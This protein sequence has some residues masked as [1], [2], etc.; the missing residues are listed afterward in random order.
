MD[1]KEILAPFADRGRAGLL[2]ALHAVQ[3]Q[4]G[5]I[6]PEAAAAIARTL[7]VPPA[8]VYSLVTFYHM[9]YDR[10][11][12]RRIVRVCTGPVCQAHGGWQLLED[13][14]RL[15]NLEEGQPDE[16]GEWMVEAAP[17]LGLCSH[18]PAVMVGEDLYGP[19]PDASA[20][21]QPDALPQPV[22]HVAG[23]VRRLTQGLPRQ[24][25]LSLEEYRAQGGY[26][27]LEQALRRLSPEA[28]RNQVKA[29]GLWGRGGAAFPT[30]LKWDYAAQAPGQPK[31]V[32]ANA[33]ESEPGT[34]KDRVLL[35]GNPH[36]MLEGLILAGYAIGAREG[37]IYLRGEYTHLYPILQHALE[38]A[39][40]AGYLGQG[41]LG[42]DFTFKVHLYRGA[43]AYVCGE[44]TAL[45]E[46]IEGKRGYPRLKPPYP[47]THG[48]FGKPTVINNVETLANVPFILREGPEAFRGYGTED[49]PGTKLFSLSGDVARP[50]VY[51]APFGL[52]LRDLLE[53]AGGV[54]GTLQA[55]LVGGAAGV[56]L[57]PDDLDWPL[58][59]DE[60]RRRGAPVA[61]GT[62]MVFNQD[63]DLKA[64]LLSIARFFMEE[65][66]GKCFPCQLGTRQQYDLLQRMFQGRAEARDQD[67][68]ANV[69]FAMHEGSICG[70]GQ[71]AGLA[72]QSAMQLWPH[73][74]R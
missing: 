59:L 65:S 24:R 15:Q 49:S 25:P 28:V 51:E 64:L 71:T 72:V 66:C 53:M 4:A 41:I 50:G 7:H 1:W 57:P 73:L 31:Y 60:G 29:A 6:P 52:T 27:A 18:A 36:L 14:L 32:V 58:T 69:I 23:P 70:L 68:L 45:F 37:Y 16:A 19:A 21:F 44:E 43:G 55:V 47:T 61:T 22:T 5:W 10:P 46:S 40:E 63:R 3:Q 12:A 39:Q 38:E 13:A 34:F 20:L 8:E 74:F 9:F 35:E 33:D 42:T 54:Q 26:A 67:R 11:T 30:G 56:F 48:L 17:C 62:I 2:P